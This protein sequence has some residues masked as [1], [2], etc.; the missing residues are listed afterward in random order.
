MKKVFLLSLAIMLLVAALV[1]AIA[2]PKSAEAWSGT[3][4]CSPTSL[5]FRVYS[6]VPTY[7]LGFIPLDS[8]QT[9]TIT[10]AGGGIAGWTVSDNAGWLNEDLLFGVI[11]GTGHSHVTVRVNTDG[12]AAGTYTATITFKL[13]TCGTKTI[14]VPVTVDVIEPKILGPLGIGADKDLSKNF[15]GGDVLAAENEYSGLTVNLLT[16]PDNMMDMQA[17]ET[18][19][20][21]DLMIQNLEQ[22]EDGSFLSNG[23]SINIR[24]VDEQLGEGYISSL[25][26]LMGMM[27][28][29][30][31][32]IDLGENYFLD[33]FTSNGD[34]YIGILLGDLPKLL[35]LLPM[36]TD[37]LSGG[38]EVGTDLSSAPP[39]GDPNGGSASASTGNTQMVIPLQPILGLLPTLMPILMDLL[40]N[41]TIMSI[42]KPLLALL[43]PI[44]IVLPGAVF[45]DLVSS[46]L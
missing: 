39:T 45:V 42:L 15:A 26:G 11:S 22:L 6:G 38:E 25:S 4:T 32:D 41:E 20:S 29:L 19:G 18:D 3:A 16:N 13:T 31:T 12:L 44:M 37:M 2:T 28:G 40:N 27:P 14:T 35:D 34:E 17:I 36:L 1:P 30:P 43:P 24:G 21:W 46:L 23:G 7:L 8:G 10:H 33:L 5:S 9:L